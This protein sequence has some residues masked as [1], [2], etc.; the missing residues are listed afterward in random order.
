MVVP[1]TLAGSQTIREAADTAEILRAAVVQGDDLCIDCGGVDE[2]D[3]TFVQLVM[4]ARKSLEAKGKTL[5]LAAKA[6]GAVLA[7]LD[8]AGIKP[9]GS[10]QFWFEARP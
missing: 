8:A 5:T 7:A 6:E 10:H 9:S 4:A 1:V 2:A 3:I